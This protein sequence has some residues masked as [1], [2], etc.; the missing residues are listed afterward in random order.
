MHD[1]SDGPS[2]R[3]AGDA[4]HTSPSVPPEPA[5]FLAAL[6]EQRAAAVSGSG[7]VVL[8][9][10]IDRFDHAVAAIGLPRAA[11]L[12]AQVQARIAGQLGARAGIHWLGERDLA[13]CA[14]L[15]PADAARLSTAIATALARPYHIDGFELFLSSS[16]GVATDLPDRAAEHSLQ[17]ALDAMLRVCRRGG[18]GIASAKIPPAPA[19]SALLTALPHALARGEFALQ[20]QPH[21]MFADAAVTGYTARLRWQHATLGRVSPQDFVPAI[22]ALGLM[23]DTGRWMLGRLLPLMQAS[24]APLQFTMLASCDQLREAEIV[25]MVRRAIDAGG[26][27]PGRLRI[28]VPA[29]ALPVSE[30]VVAQCR[31]LRESGIALALSDFIDDDAGRAAL[32]RLAPQTVMLDMRR[33]AS[34]ASR[35]AACERARAAGATVCAKGVETRQ[36]LEEARD[37]GCDAMQGYLLAQ[38][39]PAHWLAQTHTVIEQRARVLLA[40]PDT[41]ARIR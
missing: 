4:A 37:C 8:A 3:P 36:Q 11:R 21:A 6:G 14:P 26:I 13:V 9:I 35:R 1:E 38:P 19:D 5:A 20:L 22:E 10:R 32:E 18:G 23:S 41:L 12:R 33:P 31:L 27:A 2:R 34:A 15:P 29:A 30:R 24:A 7:L 40:G 16:I 28:E 17:Q 39:F 25:G